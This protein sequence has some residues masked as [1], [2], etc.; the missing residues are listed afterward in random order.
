MNI[1]EYDEF[2]A[3]IDEVKDACNFIPDVTTEEG[4]AKSKRVALDVGKILTKVESTRKDKKKYFLDGGKEVDTQAKA[5]VA[6]LEQFQLPHKEAYKELDNLKKEREASRKKALQERVDELG[7]MALNMA[8]AHSSEVM[9]A[10][11]GLQDEECLDFYE[12]TE[13]ALKARN[14]SRKDLAALYER[15]AKEEADAE[16]LAKLKKEAEER[17]IKER[18]EQIRREAS[19]KADKEKAEA[20][21]REEAAKKAQVQA[22]QDKVD[23]ERR[24]IEVEKQAKIDAEH[25][26]ERARLSEIKRQEEA[27][28][29]EAEELEKREANKR[30]VGEVRRAAKEALMEHCGLTE[31]QAKSVVLKVNSKL[32]PAIKIEY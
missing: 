24:A 32:I 25:A 1:V 21:A 8:D 6:E 3:K 12:F 27:A 20:V 19:E 13:H 17:A 11:K 9:A 29:A 14:Q 23:A 22:E 30:H 26:A 10:M 5:I 18:E 31:E 28:K 15:K 2:R 4:Y 16:E 7:L